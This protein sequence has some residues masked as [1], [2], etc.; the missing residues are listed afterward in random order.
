MGQALDGERDVNV[1]LVRD[2]MCWWYRKYAGEHSPVDQNLYEAAEA[3]AK[4][5]RKGLWSDPGPVPP[6]EW[7]RR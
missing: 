1:A 5:E 2:G 3:K 6:L 4:E 7:R